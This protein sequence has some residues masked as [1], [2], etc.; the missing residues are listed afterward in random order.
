[1]QQ[2]ARQCGNA[3]MRRCRNA[4]M[5]KYKSV[6]AWHSCTT[7]SLHSRILAFVRFAGVLMPSTGVLLMAHGTPSSL[8]EMPEYLGLVRGGR[9]PSPE[10]VA[11]MRHNYAAI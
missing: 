2:A 4:A 10:L 7:P 8:D 9:P 1:M 11:E 3:E 5:Q 6:G